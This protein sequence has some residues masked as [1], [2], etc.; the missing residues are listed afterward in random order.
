MAVEVRF[1]PVQRRRTHRAYQRR[2][3][4]VS[5]AVQGLVRPHLDCPVCTDTP[6]QQA[7]SA[8]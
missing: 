2:E 3:F 7:I 8:K 4:G 1:S 6:L 5:D